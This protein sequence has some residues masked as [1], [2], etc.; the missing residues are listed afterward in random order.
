MPSCV[1]LLLPRLIALR[2]FTI[3][4]G[5]KA[6]SFLI[7]GVRRG[8]ETIKKIYQDEDAPTNCNF[9]E[10]EKGHWWCV[11]VIWPEMKR[12]MAELDK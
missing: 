3:V 4:A 5:Q 6:P 9:I 1:F 12:L 7:E 10:T 2:R 8:Y 11:D